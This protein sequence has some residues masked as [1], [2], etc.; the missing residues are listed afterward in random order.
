M[1]WIH[2]PI[3]TGYESALAKTP[4]ASP[5][6]KGVCFC[7]GGIGICSCTSQC[8]CSMIAASPG[9]RKPDY[10]VAFKGLAV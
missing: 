8:G 3:N 6:T 10:S 9:S 2:R 1:A 7:I 4:S 5:S